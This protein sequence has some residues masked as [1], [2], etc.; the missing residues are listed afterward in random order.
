VNCAGV[1]PFAPFHE[2]TVDAFA[3]AMSL[4]VVV[5]FRFI[6]AFLAEMRAAGAGHVVTIGSVADRVAYPE[7]A[8]YAASKF[9]ARAMHEVLRA[10]TRGTGVRATLVSPGAV[11][12]AMW[13]AVNPDARADLPSRPDMLVAED[14]AMAVLFA[15]TQPPRVNV[16]ELRLSRA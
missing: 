16:D 11:D 5:P 2:L 9:G 12:T 13:D 15:L 14:V 8:A 1:F 10:E 6:R 7:N 3:E 4:N